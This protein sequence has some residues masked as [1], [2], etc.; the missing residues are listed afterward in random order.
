MVSKEEKDREYK[1]FDK[2]EVRDSSRTVDFGILFL[3]QNKIFFLI[4]VELSP[5]GFP[6]AH[7]KKRG[8]LANAS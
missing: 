3:E 5:I 8:T 4:E 1:R 6:F 2:S 7:K